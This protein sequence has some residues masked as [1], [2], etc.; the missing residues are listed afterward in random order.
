MELEHNTPIRFI[1]PID[2]SPEELKARAK[3]MDDEVNLIMKEYFSS[4]IAVENALNRSFFDL[5][6]KFINI[7][8]LKK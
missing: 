4:N 8:I 5:L 3:A 1:P 7:H 2:Y 6:K